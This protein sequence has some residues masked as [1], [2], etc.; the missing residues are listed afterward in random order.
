VG[1]FVGKNRGGFA[2]ANCVFGRNLADNFQRKG[3]K[4]QRF[5]NLFAA[6]LERHRL[7]GANGHPA[8]TGFRCICFAP[9]RFEFQRHSS[10]LEKQPERLSTEE[11]LWEIAGPAIWAASFYQAE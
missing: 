2:E 8:V 9:L 11:P 3:S 4:A 7:A 5:S 6:R 1:F 10:G